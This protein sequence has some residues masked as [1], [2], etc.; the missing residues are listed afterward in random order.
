MAKIYG[1][2]KQNEKGKQN[3]DLFGIALLVVIKQAEKISM[4]IEDL[5]LMFS[6]RPT[7]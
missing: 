2:K 6:D 1:Q 4:D 5:K 3:H 7:L